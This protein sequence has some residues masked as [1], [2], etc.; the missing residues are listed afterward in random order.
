MTKQLTTKQKRFVDNH[1]LKG[2]SI[3]ESVRR[4]N[5]A[6]K[7]GRSEDYGSLGCR[8]LK[9]ERVASYVSKL[10]EKQFSKDL[11]SVSEK[12]AF[13]A[14]AVRTPVGELDEASDLVQEMTYNESANGSSKKVRG[15]DKLRALELDSRIAGDF[16]SDRQPNAT[17]AFQFI[18]QLGK[19]TSESV[20]IPSQSPAIRESS[21]IIE[22][23]AQLIAP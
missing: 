20:S 7:S 13:L 14:R 1:I 21:E 18:I 17:N 12:R 6:I 2:M 11:L 19:M 15:V 3:A 8:M 22:A 16:F 10:R 5:Y 9:T 4:A 23:D